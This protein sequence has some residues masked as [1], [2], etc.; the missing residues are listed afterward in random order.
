MEH[1]LRG[2]TILLVGTESRVAIL[3]RRLRKSGA[4]LLPF[5]TVRIAPP[6][7]PA[8]LDRA[9]EN[10]AS[11]DWVVFTS[12][13][14]VDQVVARAASL[15]IPFR[16]PGRPKIAAVGPATRAA[17]IAAGF[18]VDAMPSRYL[19]DRIPDAIG[20]ARGLRILLPRSNLARESLAD[21]LRSRGASVDEVDAYE[22]VPTSPDPALLTGATRV[23]VI[24]FTSASAARNLAAVVP[25]SALDRIRRSG[26]A[27]CIGPVTADAAKELGFRVALVA[28]KHTVPGIVRGLQELTVDG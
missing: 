12:S 4:I 11:Y 21:I 18:L 25:P 22:S 3:A 17:A 28:A 19:T 2:R 10:W 24:V 20:P 5:P 15:G 7:N 14:G 6:R 27:V 23:D 16:S 1:G 13:N 8:A 26:I 9:I